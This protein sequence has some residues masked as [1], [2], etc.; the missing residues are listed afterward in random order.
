M[1]YHDENQ[2]TVINNYKEFESE[3]D[4]IMNFLEKETTTD[5]DLLELVKETGSTFIEV[6]DLPRPYTVDE[7]RE[8]K[9]NNIL[10]N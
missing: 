4:E 1:D 6:V 8:L 7:V 9:L 10:D 2:P 3:I 5:P